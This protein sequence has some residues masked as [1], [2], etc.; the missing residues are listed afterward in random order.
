METP[1]TKLATKLVQL[2]MTVSKTEKVLKVESLQAIERQQT[3]LKTITTKIE[4]LKGEV[5]AK[6]IT[7]KE[8]HEE[9]ENWIS[10][11]DEELS[12]A[13]IELK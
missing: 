6:K 8:S 12:K 3:S 10:E 4:L 13:D 9:I 2:R 11:I 7:E 5:K 1:E